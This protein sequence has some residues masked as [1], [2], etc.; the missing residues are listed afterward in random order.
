MQKNAIMQIAEY[1]MLVNNAFA[2]A[3]HHELVS[4]AL[5]KAMV[6]YAMEPI[7]R[8]HWKIPEDGA[9]MRWI[10]YIASVISSMNAV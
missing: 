4:Y 9:K 3:L 8:I 2:E 6:K 10:T 5:R 7:E 1:I